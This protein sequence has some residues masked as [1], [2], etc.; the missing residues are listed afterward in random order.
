MDRVFQFLETLVRKAARAC[1][2]L[3]I[4]LKLALLGSQT[5][6]DGI[7]LLL[8]ANV[9]STHMRNRLFS[10]GVDG[11]D[12]RLLRR[13]AHPGDFLLNIGCGCGL[14]AMAA[15]RQVR[16]TGQ[17]MALEPDPRVHELA[18]RNF[19]LNG[20]SEIQS[21]AAAAV[22]ERATKE[23]TFYRKKNYYG[24]SL[25]QLDSGAEPIRVA[26]VYPPDVTPAT[27]AGRK[28]LLC[29]V[30]GYEATLLSVEEIID[31]FDLIIVELHF[32]WAEKNVVSPYV[33]M[34]D[35]LFSRGFKLVDLDDEGFVFERVQTAC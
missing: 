27:C 18:R 31:C 32:T 35:T 34:F 5:E 11:E 30:E 28:I 12:R 9:L 8:P 24:S 6:V 4:R 17:V 25:L 13:Y 29:D 10:G 7:R 14:S 2:L 19:E 20:M 1:E 3:L 15:W 21:R 33:R 26:G 23:V 16:P 22:A